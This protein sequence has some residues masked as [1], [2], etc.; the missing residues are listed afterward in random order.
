MEPLVLEKKLYC[1]AEQIFYENKMPSLPEF[2]KILRKESSLFE[3]EIV[4][5]ALAVCMNSG[6][7]GKFNN[8]EA[9]LELEYGAFCTCDKH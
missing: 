4:Q 8:L 1:E 6:M 3:E 2:V 5:Y 7:L 9:Y